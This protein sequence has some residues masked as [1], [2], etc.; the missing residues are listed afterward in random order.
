MDHDA[1]DFDAIL[2]SARLGDG[3]AFEALFRRFN[4]PLASFAAARQ[5][6]DPEGV[7]NETFVRVFRSLP[8]FE[9]NE[10]QFSGWLFRIARN[11][12]IDDVR[13][14]GRRLHEIPNES[15]SMPSA[16][17]RLDASRPQ[18]AAEALAL[19][20]FE[21]ED[22]ERHLDDLTPEQRDII[23][24]RVVSD[25]SIEVVAATLGKS[26]SAVKS[27]QFRAIRQLRNAL[28]KVSV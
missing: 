22:I 27:S 11:L 14:Q 16:P 23:L 20:R 3:S 26:I 13:R 21:N 10:A 9:G 1:H 18:P 24:L 28:E 4:R 12:V 5:A 19:E 8:T 15:L 25:Q 17:D 6:A 2:E 7:V